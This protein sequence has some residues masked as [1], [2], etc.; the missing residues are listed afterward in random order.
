MSDIKFY[1]RN[2]AI[3]DIETTGLSIK[4]HE[5]IELAAMIYD[6]QND[7]VLEELEI[8]VQPRHLETASP[9]ALS[10]NGFSKVAWE[11]AWD[12]NSA[13]TEF[14]IF[15]R[16]CI[17]VGHNVKFDL[18]HIEKALEEFDIKPMYDYHCVT[19]DSLAWPLVSS[20]RLDGIGLATLCDYFGISNDGAHTAL[21][22][23]RRTLQLYKKLILHYNNS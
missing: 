9:E 13:I 23:C 2:M 15:I 20:N 3:I 7:V 10:I 4:D 18:A 16:D 8:K 17:P 5:I 12:L 22:D 14:N 6:H 19:T 1:D 11:E 21:A